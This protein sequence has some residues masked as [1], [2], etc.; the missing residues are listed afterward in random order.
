MLKCN[1][2]L[3]RLNLTAT[4]SNQCLIWQEN[5]QIYQRFV[6]FNLIYLLFVGKT[7]LVTT[8]ADCKKTLNISLSLYAKETLII[9][10]KLAYNI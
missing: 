10:A 6:K 7:R 4:V 5:W 1:Y 8:Q 3:L 9:V 2:I